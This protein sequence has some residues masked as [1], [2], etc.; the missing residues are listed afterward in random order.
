MEKSRFGIPAIF[1]SEGLCGLM[2]R[3]FRRFSPPV[4][5][6]FGIPVVGDRERHMGKSLRWLCG[7]FTEGRSRRPLRRQG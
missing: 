5:E 1:H 4:L 3:A 6:F 7:K 2:L